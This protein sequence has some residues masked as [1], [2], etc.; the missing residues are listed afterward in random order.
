MNVHSRRGQLV[1][2]RS[3]REPVPGA[4]F[5]AAELHAEAASPGARHAGGSAQRRACGSAPRSLGGQQR[6]DLL[7]YGRPVRHTDF[8][9]PSIGTLLQ[10]LLELPVPRPQV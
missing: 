3:S 1:P 8:L 10:N 2:C 6:E 7:G 5:P 4:E 9:L